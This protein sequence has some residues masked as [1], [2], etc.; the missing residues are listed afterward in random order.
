MTLSGLQLSHLYRPAVPADKH[1]SLA[2]FF[3]SLAL[4]QIGIEIVDRHHQTSEFGDGQVY[5]DCL[6]DPRELAESR[7]LCQSH[8][9]VFRPHTT[10]ADF[11][12]EAKGDK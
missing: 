11:W 6:L 10:E 1:R 3:L 9:E 12:R 8:S 7:P 2:F 5:R 4:N